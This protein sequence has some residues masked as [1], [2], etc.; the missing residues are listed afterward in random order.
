MKL[1]LGFLL[2]V[3]LVTAALAQQ[4][5]NTFKQLRTLSGKEYTEVVVTAVLPDSIRITHDAGTAT[6]QLADLPPELQKQFNYDLAAAATYSLRMAE[7]R[8]AA[9]QAE[10]KARSVAASTAAEKKAA[11]KAVEMVVE[12][13]QVMS[14][15]ALVAPC[16]EMGDGTAGTTPSYVAGGKTIFLRGISGVT[17]GEKPRVR[18]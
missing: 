18:A 11:E 16:R 17:D 14:G 10:A 9:A 4:A 6:V 15:G 3:A 13:Q 2:G 8:A 1:I 12:V 7:A 5:A